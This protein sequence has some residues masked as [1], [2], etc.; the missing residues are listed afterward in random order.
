M[1]HLKTFE[2]FSI[3]EENKFR[4]FFFGKA[5][6]SDDDDAVEEIIRRLEKVV[7]SNNPYRI[8]ALTRTP[9]DRWKDEFISY[10][11]HFDD[12]F[13][14]TTYYT[15]RGPGGSSSST[16]EVSIDPRDDNEYEKLKV[17]AGLRKKLFNLV[18]SI[19]KEQ[20]KKPSVKYGLNK[21]SDL[22]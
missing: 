1:Q 14:T 3:N 5:P 22:L 8:E 15:S 16:Y 21:A 6:Q 10:K 11:V 13:V 12:C 4:D 18:N 9:D 17:R 7:P 20:N 19:Y 2:N